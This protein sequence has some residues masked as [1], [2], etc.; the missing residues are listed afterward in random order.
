MAKRGGAPEKSAN[1]SE[2]TKTRNRERQSI[3]SVSSTWGTAFFPI[4]SVSTLAT[5]CM[6]VA[7][8]I[9]NRGDAALMETYMKIAEKVFTNGAALGLTIYSITEAME[10][11]MVFANYLRQ[12]LLEP[13][14]ERQ[15]EEGREEMRE[16]A[17]EAREEGRAEGIKIGRE[18]RTAREREG[19]RE[20]GT[21]RGREEGRENG[22]ARERE[23]RTALGREEWLELGSLRTELKW[24]SWNERRERAAASGEPFDEPPPSFGG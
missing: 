19:G 16:E 3:W 22:I 2:R 4:F 12:N 20:N 7:Y 17:R 14:K 5:S 15:R 10:T 23:E 8:L 1:G 9:A 18:E 21:A 6:I 13:L 24:R 11:A